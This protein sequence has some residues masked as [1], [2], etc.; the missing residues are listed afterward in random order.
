MHGSRG[1]GGPSIFQGM[2]FKMVKLG[3]TQP[4]MKLDPTLGKFSRSVHD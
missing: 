3:W 2:G 4:G 1:G